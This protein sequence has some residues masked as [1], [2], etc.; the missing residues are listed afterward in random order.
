ML[1]ELTPVPNKFQDIDGLFAPDEI[2]VSDKLSPKQT[3]VSSGPAFA[4]IS[5]PGS[6]IT[7]SFAVQ[8]LVSVTKT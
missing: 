6:N 8:P 1:L 3:N 2:P 7:V 4:I 5:N